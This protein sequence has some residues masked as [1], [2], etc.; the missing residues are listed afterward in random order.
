MFSCS[1]DLE[2]V[3]S[4]LS[5]A[6]FSVSFELASHGVPA[7]LSIFTVYSPTERHWVPENTPPVA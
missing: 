7:E 2:M 1:V 3:Y 5:I 6:V 4:T